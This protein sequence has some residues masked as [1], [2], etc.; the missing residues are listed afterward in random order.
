MVCL[1]LLRALASW[2]LAAGGI[3]LVLLLVAFPAE[4]LPQD[5]QAWAEALGFF[6][7]FSGSKNASDRARAAL[8]IGNATS[9]KHD[10]RAWQ[11]LSALL[12]QELARDTQDGKTEERVSGE[13]LE[14]CVKALA[15]ITEKD[16]LAEMAKAARN[17]TDHVRVR[18]YLVWALGPRGNLK[19][20]TDL[21]EDKLPAIQVAALDALAERAD[22]SLVDVFLKCL[23]EGRSWEIKLAAVQGLERTATEDSV[24][25]IIETLTICRPEEGRI[26][27]RLSVT[28]RKTTKLDLESD[29][30][31]AWRAA[32]TAKKAGEEPGRAGT[33]AEPAEFFGLR[34]PS[35]RIVFILD[36]TGT[37]GDAARD[38]GRTAGK[39]PQ[40]AAPQPKEPRQE[41]AAR[42]EATRL[43]E[44]IE[45]SAASTR[46]EIAKRE[47]VHSVYHL[48]PRVHF[49]VVLFESVPH[50]WRDTFVPA[51]WPNKLELIREVQKLTPG[52]NTNM[53]DAIEMA[54]RFVESP[55][56]P[57]VFT[58]DKKS[59][60]AILLGGA[61]TFYFLSDGLPNAGRIPK[62]EDILMELAK[63][64]RLR[65]V[66]IHAV[67]IGDVPPD[68]TPGGDY[69]DPVFMKKIADLTGGTFAHVCQER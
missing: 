60:Y 36:R 51:T 43:K 47:L 26:R 25:A 30:P 32:W 49:N 22:P 35:S 66:A 9:E 6:Q 67:C 54:L 19:D 10:R 69:P 13:V 16:V 15:R 20:L 29:D 61:D 24:S 21:A 59:N 46:L 55:Q 52:G 38:P 5:R 12:R 37:M 64:S 18:L 33:V 17:R 7:R 28:L 58:L 42:E 31:N 63:V 3:R 4:G 1:Q 40:D 23:R 14:A 68:A 2:V 11:L 53:W 50:G 27:E 65:K 34:S 48:S 8:E 57:G 56:R 41:T 39:L 44:R 62:A 45:S